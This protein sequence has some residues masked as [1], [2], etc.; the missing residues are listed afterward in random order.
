MTQFGL[1]AD[2]IAEYNPGYNRVV[3]KDLQQIGL[4]LAADKEV[5]FNH[6]LA[7]A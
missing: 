3:C 1:S 6:E 4:A 5:T 7:S 2:C